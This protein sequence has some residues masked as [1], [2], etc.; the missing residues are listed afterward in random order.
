MSKVVKTSVLVIGATGKQGSKVVDELLKTEKYKVFGTTRHAPNFAIDKKGA[1]SVA[2]KF[3]SRESIDKA[4][5]ET[6][7]KLVYF[8]TD[9]FGAA[10][11]R[12]DLEAEHGQIIVDAC[13]EAG[14]NHVVFS[15]AANVDTC[16]SEIHHLTSKVDVE[17]YLKESKLSYSILRPVAFFENFDDPKNW[18]SLRK[19]H[20]K[21]LWKGDVKIKMIGCTDIAKAAVKMF[22]EPEKWNGKTLDCASCELTGN[23]VAEALS[24]VSGIKC[25]YS[26]V[27]PRFLLALFMNDLYK[28]VRW[29][30]SGTA[31]DVSIEEFKKVVPDA[32]GPKEFFRSI[33]Q[34]SNG[35]K[36]PTP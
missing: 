25:K 11:K 33:G 4:L 7:S 20:V 5:S 21:C 36:F 31:F 16:P 13:K 30:E 22:E 9:F 18:N 27:L 23:E 2:F 24:E 15:S 1:T 12:R 10:G 8:L 19:G 17:K 32:Q 29:F 28:M 6:Q 34:W 14:V 26:T 35:E 3:G